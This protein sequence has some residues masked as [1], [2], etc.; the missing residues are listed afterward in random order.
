MPIAL[1]PI[2]RD[3]IRRVGTVDRANRFRLIRRP[4]ANLS[5]IEAAEQRRLPQ[6]APRVILNPRAFAVP[7]S[8]TPIIK[9]MPLA[10]LDRMANRRAIE[11]DAVGV[12][13]TAMVR[14]GYAN[15]IRMTGLD[16]QGALMALTAARL[17]MPFTATAAHG[18]PPLDAPWRYKTG[19]VLVAVGLGSQPVAVG[20]PIVT[21]LSA[22]TIDFAISAEIRGPRAIAIAESVASVAISRVARLA[23][24]QHAVATPALARR[25]ADV[26]LVSAALPIVRTGARPTLG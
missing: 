20:G 25:H 23:R 2:G 8:A 16:R 10:R 24:V 4:V 11:R 3:A 13:T 9:A 12:S 5:R 7:F 15:P 1:E 21:G 19:A 17:T 22:L 26:A 18:A 6:S 14:C